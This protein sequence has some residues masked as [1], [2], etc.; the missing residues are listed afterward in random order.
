[1]VAVGAGAAEELKSVRH[2]ERVKD[3]HRELN[4][5]KVARA[6]ER[7]E[8]AG[9]AAVDSLT[10]RQL[11]L[12]A[13]TEQFQG[14]HVTFGLGSKGG[15][16][17]AAR[18][19]VVEVVEQDR[20]R[21]LLYR[22]PPDVVRVQVCERDARDTRRDRLRDVHCTTPRASVSGLQ[23]I[24]GLAAYSRREAQRGPEPYSG[25][26]GELGESV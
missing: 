8:A 26:Y 11:P 17:H 4:V 22:D 14:S 13:S 24:E 20:V 23:K 2:V 9:R 21:D 12:P 18:I 19:R 6:V 3:G 15:V 16:V 25:A 1:M 10:R 5:T 7:R